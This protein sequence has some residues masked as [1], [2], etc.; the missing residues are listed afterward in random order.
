MQG[1]NGFSVMQ[2]LFSSYKIYASKLKIVVN[3]Q[4]AIDTTR[5][6][7]SC[8][9]YNEYATGIYPLVPY[10]E[11]AY[12][13][14]KTITVAQ[15]AEPGVLQ[16]KVQIYKVLGA[17]KR[18]YEDVLPNT[19]NSTS[20]N[21]TYDCIWFV[22]WHL[23]SAAGSNTGNIYVEATITCDIEMMVPYAAVS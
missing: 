15:G 17:K 2:G 11:D 8:V 3:N 5:W 7:L 21:G 19:F 23:L 16:N 18:Q 9:P 12:S 13:N 22:N 10:Q 6:T 14:T 4:S 20:T 1:Y